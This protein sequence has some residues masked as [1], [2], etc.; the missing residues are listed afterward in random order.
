VGDTSAIT[1]VLA[2]I[3]SALGRIERRQAAPER[4]LLSRNEVSKLLGVDKAK[5][6]R[7]VREGR[8]TEVDLDGVKRIPRSEVARIERE[9]LPPVAR[10]P[11]RQR[12]RKDTKLTE[13]EV[14]AALENY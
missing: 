1:T 2:D 4:R 11:R 8:L 13:A 5:V 10:R 6:S 14:Q 7:W 3:V 12:Q 9:G